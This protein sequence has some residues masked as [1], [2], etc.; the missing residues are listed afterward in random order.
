MKRVVLL[1]TLAICVAAMAEAA[2]APAPKSATNTKSTGTSN[3]RTA[4]TTAPAATKTAPA[5][6]ATRKVHAAPKAEREP[7]FRGRMNLGFRTMGGSLGYVSPEHA[8]GTFD[9]GL[10]ADCGR[11]TPQIA[12][13]P[14]LDYWSW[15]K[16]S[17]GAKASARDIIV[18]MRGKYLFET[19]NPKLQPF[20]G[21]GLSMHFIH[22]EVTIPVP[23]GFPEMK[24]EDSAT[25][26]GLDI[27]GG[28][29]TP[30]GPRSDLLGEVWYGIV[31]DV[32]QFSMR[33]GM[34][35]RLGQ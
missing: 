6:T 8:D 17:F 23:A 21:A 14:R 9:M 7:E 16:E 19:A 18:G 10:F 24:A 13:E 32:S 15:S 20:A 22:T 4:A 34:S 35:Y 29:S 11:I 2:T 30:I 12:L 26:L 1:L 5:A 31:S 3:A 33:V 25:R 28:V 27:G